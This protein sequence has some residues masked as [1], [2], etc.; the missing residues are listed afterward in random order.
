MTQSLNKRRRNIVIN[1]GS[2][3]SLQFRK[4]SESV[5][6]FKPLAKLY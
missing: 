6:T 2:P 3:A 5:V 1:S 4:N